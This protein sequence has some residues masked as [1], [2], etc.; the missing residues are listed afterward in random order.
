MLARE[1]S[2]LT[3]ARKVP[4]LAAIRFRTGGR[5]AGFSQKV[6]AA[7]PPS[8]TWPLSSTRMSSSPVLLRPFSS[9]S[10]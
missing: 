4:G 6:C 2:G 1:K 7:P 9:S 10:R 3:T 5:L 8:M